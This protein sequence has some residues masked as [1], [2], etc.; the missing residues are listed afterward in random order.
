MHVSGAPPQRECRECESDRTGGGEASKR[1]IGLDHE[2]RGDD[3]QKLY[4]NG[5]KGEDQV[6]GMASLRIV[7]EYDHL[8]DEFGLLVI[9]ATLP[10]VK[11]QEVIRS[12][13]VPHLEGAL[14][15]ESNPWRYVLSAQQLS[16]RYLSDL[17]DGGDIDC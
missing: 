10:I 1:C 9:D 15:A 16:G 12:I 2:G 8:V 5:Q 17:R 14:R 3:Q 4:S 7:R 11:Q 13:I 6:R